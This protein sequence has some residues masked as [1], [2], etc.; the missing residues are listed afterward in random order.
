MKTTGSFALRRL[1]GMA[2]M[3]VHAALCA[4]PLTWF[5]GPSLDTPA[6]GAATTIAGSLGNLVIGGTSYFSFESYPESLVATNIYWTPL[7]PIYSVRIAPGAVA[8]GGIIVV[9]G[10]TDGTNSTSTVVGYSP[11]GDTPLELASMSV[12]RSYLAYAPDGNGRAYAIGGLD[13]AGQPL[14]SAER[15]DPDADSWAGPRVR[16]GG[17]V[18]G[19]VEPG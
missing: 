7:P 11:S 4:A 19:A 2:P 10:G 14:F 13:D 15:Y 8:N 1:A 3:F 17:R 16:L 9:Y 12:A 6:S 18:Q 5:P